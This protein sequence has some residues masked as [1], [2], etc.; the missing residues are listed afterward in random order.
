VYVDSIFRDLVQIGLAL[1]PSTEEHMET[2]EH[3][4][5]RSARCFR[6]CIT[7]HHYSR[8]ELKGLVLLGY[9]LWERSVELDAERL[10]GPKAEQS[11]QPRMLSSSVHMT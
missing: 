3:C 5:E 1:P 10:Q 7:T 4:L 11:G 9:A 8:L 6:E 2:P